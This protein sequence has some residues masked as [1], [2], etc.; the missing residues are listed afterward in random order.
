MERA[1]ERFKDPRGLVIKEMREMVRRIEEKGD[2][3][4][5]TFADDFDDML[6]DGLFYWFSEEGDAI[7]GF[8]RFLCRHFNLDYVHVHKTQL[9]EFLEIA[10]CITDLTSEQERKFERLARVWG[11]PDAY[12]KIEIEEEGKR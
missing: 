6:G 2:S 1:K 8:S 5:E 12:P 3:F 10:S 9:R 7:S 4:Y 11:I